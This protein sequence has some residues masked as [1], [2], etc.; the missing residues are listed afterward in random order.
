MGA[1]ESFHVSP[2]TRLVF[3][4]DRR[5]LTGYRLTRNDIV[6]TANSD[7]VQQA[8][9]R[10][11]DA[12]ITCSELTGLPVINVLTLPWTAPLRTPS[13]RDPLRAKSQC[14]VF[15]YMKRHNDR[16][17][18]MWTP[19][20]RICGPDDV[21]VVLDSY[22]PTCTD[23]F[24]SEHSDVKRL[25]EGLG[26]VMPDVIGY[27]HTVANPITRKSSMGTE[28][29]EWRK[30]KFI[31]LIGTSEITEL[32]EDLGWSQTSYYDSLDPKSLTASLGGD[33]PIV[34]HAIRESDG[35]KAVNRAKRPQLDAAK[36]IKTFR[37]QSE[38]AREVSLVKLIER[39]PLLKANGNGLGELARHNKNLWVDYVNLVDSVTVVQGK[40]Q[41]E[42]AA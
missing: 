23:E 4:D 25:L 36:Y 37:K 28:W 11:L 38:L 3:R 42:K 30:T 39:Y 10:Q 17:S 9:R 16:P 18:D 24:V 41:Q 26:F 5:A 32:V 2:E 34:I 29:H 14:F 13:V 31:E 40:K 21:Y 1:C 12:V 7:G 6:V 19:A 20:S 15:D 22:R 8:A 35:S 33:H 27:R